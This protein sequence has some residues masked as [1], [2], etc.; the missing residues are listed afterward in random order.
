LASRLYP[1]VWFNA[2]STTTQPK[3]TTCELEAITGGIVLMKNTTEKRSVDIVLSLT[4]HQKDVLEDFVIFWDLDM[5]VIGR[6]VVRYFIRE[7]VTLVDLLNKHRAAFLD[8]KLNCVVD[9]NALK[10]YKLRVYLTE[11]EKRK[12]NALA[13]QWGCRPS[14]IA[15]MLLH[16]F[17]SGVIGKGDIWE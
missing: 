10:L 7:K 8:G 17:V 1:I 16:F 4:E 12:L 14:D 6:L 3:N 15:R 13:D 2:G 11:E 9:L 5:A